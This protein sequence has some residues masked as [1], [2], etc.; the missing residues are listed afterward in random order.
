MEFGRIG[1]KVF[2]GEDKGQNSIEIGRIHLPMMSLPIPV[3]SF[4][5]KTHSTLEK[6]KL[7]VN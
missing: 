2:A 6:F 1:K 4:K 5:L 7:L 3:Y